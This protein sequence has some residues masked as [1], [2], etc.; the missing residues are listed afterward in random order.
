MV[1]AA[2]LPELRGGESRRGGRF[3]PL[4]LRFERQGDRR[5]ARPVVAAAGQLN[6]AASSKFPAVAARDVS[7]AKTAGVHVVRQPLGIALVR[8]RRVDG[9]EPIGPDGAETSGGVA[10]ILDQPLQLSGL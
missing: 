9:R 7:V 1:E 5:A 8:L 2:R 10:Q 6:E 4:G 3:E